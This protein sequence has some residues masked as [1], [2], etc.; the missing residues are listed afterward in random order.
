MT[1]PVEQVRYVYQGPYSAGDTVPIPFS[2]REVQHV[3]AATA[4][5]TLTINVDYSVLGQNLTFITPI[6]TDVNVVVYRQTPLD[7]DAEFPQEAEF[8]SEKINDSIDKLTMIVQ[9]Q[10]DSLNRALQIPSV[11]P[12][13]S[14]DTFVPSPDAGKALKWDSTGTFLINSTYDPDSL[15]NIATEQ[16]RIATEQANIATQKAEETA[17]IVA[18]TYT[19]NE[20]NTFL[21]E[22]QDV[23]T[24][25]Q[26]M[27]LSNNV[28][29][30][31]LN[32]FMQ[33]FTES[34][35]NGMS[36]SEQAAIPLALIYE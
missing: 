19:K 4:D 12:P 8:D 34:A 21:G 20:I 30:V 24:P 33:G 6:E 7:N 17:A 14:L 9:E 3:R 1:L 2:Y 32:S 23:L 13:D 28:V 10:Q 22:K 35:W 5:K 25:G 11:V 36:A 31:N 29:D 18:N 27:T 26:Y 16:A 15:A